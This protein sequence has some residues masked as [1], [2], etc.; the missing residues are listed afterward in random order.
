MLIPE[1]RSNE[2]KIKQTFTII[3]SRTDAALAI[4]G[5]NYEIVFKPVFERRGKEVG[6]LLEVSSLVHLQDPDCRTIRSGS[7]S[8][9]ETLYRIYKD[10]SASPW[11]FLLT[12]AYLTGNESTPRGFLIKFKLCLLLSLVSTGSKDK[13]HVLALGTDTNIISR[14]SKRSFYL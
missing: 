10:R 2:L 12:L 9:P 8:V 4:L 6:I 13:I 11:S 3:L 1:T 14:F 7:V 5:Q